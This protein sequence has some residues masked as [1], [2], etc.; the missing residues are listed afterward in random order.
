MNFTKNKTFKLKK[1]VFIPKLE[2][3]VCR[4]DAIT[5]CNFRTYT[6]SRINVNISISYLVM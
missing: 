4:R 2:S 5:R 3:H 1:S 6:Q